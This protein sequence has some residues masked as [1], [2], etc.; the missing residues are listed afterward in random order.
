MDI[1]LWVLYEM[2]FSLIAEG[3]VR[4]TYDPLERNIILFI[5]GERSEPGIEAN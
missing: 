2:L 4:T 1:D 5:P 3:R